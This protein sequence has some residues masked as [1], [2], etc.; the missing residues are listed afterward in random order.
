MIGYGDYAGAVI[1]L[2]SIIDDG[3]VS[4]EVYLLRA[5]AYI[6]L[7]CHN[8][9]IKDCTLSL[10]KKV[11]QEA[12]FIRGKCKYYISDS[13]YVNDL[14][15]G[16]YDGH[17]FLTEIG[18]YNKQTKKQKVSDNSYPKRKKKEIKEKRQLKKDPNFKLD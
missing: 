1:K 11:T 8:M 4:Y 10:G 5:K 18:Y 17:R 16:G 14:E 3:W 6:E 7:G 12:Y 15:K 2:N 9:A 13:S